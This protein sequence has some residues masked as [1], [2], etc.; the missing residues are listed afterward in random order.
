ME[1]GAE[2]EVRRAGIE[3]A[4]EAARLLRA[5]NAEYEEPSPPLPVLAERMRG[6]LSGDSFVVLLAGRPALGIA[7]LRLRRAL[8]SSG[9]DA[10]LEELYVVPEQRRRGFGRRLLESAAAAARRAGADHFE[11]T[12]AETDTEARALY[13]SFGMTNHEGGPG[14]PRMLYYELDL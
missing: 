4:A 6:L 14:G 11:L 13:E 3:D 7:V 5:F 10:Y 2:I 8:W 9:A 12:T 1:N